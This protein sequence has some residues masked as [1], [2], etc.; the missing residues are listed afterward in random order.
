MKHKQL[1]VYALGQLNIG[2]NEEDV[3]IAILEKICDVFSMDTAFIYLNEPSKGSALQLQVQINTSTAV[4]LPKSI[5]LEELFSEIEHPWFNSKECEDE[6]ANHCIE[7]KLA[8]LFLTNKLAILAISNNG[9]LI[10]IVGALTFQE[11]LSLIAEDK[12]LIRLTLAICANNVKL[13]VSKQQVDYARQSLERTVD[14]TGVDIYVTD[15]Y[16]YEILYTNRSMAAPYDG[17]DHLVGKKCYLALYDDKTQEC[18]FCPRSK[19]IDEEGNPTK[20]YSWDYQ[21]PF[22]GSWFRVFSA[23]FKWVDGRLA[24]V[25][26]S[27]DIT[28]NKKNEYLIEKMALYDALTEIPNRRSFERDFERVIN[29]I[30]RYGQTGYLVFVDLDNFKYINDAFGHEKGDELLRQVAAHLRSLSIHSTS[31]YRYGGD[32]FILLLEKANI[33]QVKAV[34]DELLQRF[35]QPWLLDGLEYFCTASMGVACFPKDGLTYDALLNAADLAMYQAKKNGKSSVFFS[36]GE[37]AG[38]SE[39]LEREFALRRAVA[40]DC[41]EFHLLFH[42]IVDAKS[43]AWSGGEVLIRWESPQW[44]LSYPAEFIPI[45]EKLGLISQ[46]GRWTL[47]T[48]LAQV[49]SWNLNPSDNFLVSFNVSILEIQDAGFIEYLLTTLDNLHYPYSNIMLELTESKKMYDTG[50]IKEQI[51]FLRKKGM[52]VALDGFGIGYS[53]LERIRDL[54]ID[55][56]KVDRKFIMNF[57]DDDLMAALVKAIAMLGHAAHTKV[58]AEGVENEA[59]RAALADMGYNYLQGVYFQEPLPEA[60]F[61]EQLLANR[62]SV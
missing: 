60:K 24:H 53:S 40:D 13:S 48:A 16:T 3:N 14:H 44:G 56:I 18:D 58:C 9:H 8:A 36:T 46:L 54:E 42:P 47:A 23:A 7:K 51:R 49:T 61:K 21:R 32:E 59:H 27:V 6:V 52:L 12:N 37:V 5:P 30:S 2:K 20:I 55:F 57:L 33:Q 45:C 41:K 35:L 50:G 15:F 11:E 29:K 25:I 31:A 39:Q 17:T 62:G 22:D 19:L 10:G 1:L 34:T 28:E 26:T 43:G 38:R 4:Q